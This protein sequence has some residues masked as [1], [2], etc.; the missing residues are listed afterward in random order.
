MPRP[1]DRRPWRALLAAL[2][3]ALAAC[4]GGDGAATD[5]GPATTDTPAGRDGEDRGGEDGG[6]DDGDG[7]GPDTGAPA[8]GQ[9]GP[10]R[11]L[12][13]LAEHADLPL[14]AFLQEVFGFPVTAPVPDLELTRVYTQASGLAGSA[15][16]VT[17][18]AEYAAPD[19]DVDAVFAVVAD[20]FDPAVWTAAGEVEETSPGFHGQAW[21][22]TADEVAA[23]QVTFQAEAG[24][25]LVNV[26]SRLVT[27]PPA[28]LWPW[29]GDVPVAPAA[30]PASWLV[31]VPD[32]GGGPAL[33]LDMRWRGEVGD[34]DALAAFVAA[35]PPGAL[36]PGEV[37]TGTDP[38]TETE[39]AVTGDG[40]F[41]GSL[42]AVLTQA[43]RE[44]DVIL[45][46]TVPLG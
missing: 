10:V 39:V 38:F 18:S 40:G 28:A 21:T 22:A 46:G 12:P 26:T 15:A 34:H 31:Q 16:S 35:L 17:Y 7:T 5:D 13:G 37:T 42:S 11:T 9:G 20:A 23:A 29:A 45:V 24:E 43:D 25:L 27:D 3:L 6:G 19:G 14:D 36:T 30:S 32:A 8:V 1:A 2:V 44:P 4:G 33:L 41:T